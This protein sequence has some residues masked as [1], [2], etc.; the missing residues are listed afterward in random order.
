MNLLRP[1][2]WRVLALCLAFSLPS[3]AEESVPPE[4]AA[5]IPAGFQPLRYQ[6]NDFNNDD[7]LDGLL[8]LHGKGKERPVLLLLRGDDD[9]LALAVRNDHAILP[10][11]WFSDPFDEVTVGT[12][13]FSLAQREGNSLFKPRFSWSRAQQ[14][15]LLD[16][17]RLISYGKVR[18]VEHIIGI[19]TWKGNSLHPVPFADFSAREH[20]LD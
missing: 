11:G 9:K 20:L 5:F 3:Q 7:R 10:K 18:D 16:E 14:T 4:V 8:M 17:I 6:A 15:W 19:S 2:L 1:T 12:G 13:W